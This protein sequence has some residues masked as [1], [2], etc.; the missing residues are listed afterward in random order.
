MGVGW[1]REPITPAWAPASLC[2]YSHPWLAVLPLGCSHS[3]VCVDGSVQVWDAKPHGSAPYTHHSLSQLSQPSKAQQQ[4]G[5]CHPPTVPS[6]AVSHTGRP[7]WL[8]GKSWCFSCCH[9]FYGFF[10]DNGTGTVFLL[11]QSMGLWP[12]RARAGGQR[13]GGRAQTWVPACCVLPPLQGQ[14]LSPGVAGAGGFMSYC[15]VPSPAICQLLLLHLSS[16]PLLSS[17]VTEGDGDLQCCQRGETPAQE[18]V[19]VGARR[20]RERGEDLH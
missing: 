8:T 3:W 7:L 17:V 20:H 6:R 2:L 18:M 16:S 4:S 11:L 9:P 5:P 10:S 15:R 12:H 14:C 19:F 1:H 13:P